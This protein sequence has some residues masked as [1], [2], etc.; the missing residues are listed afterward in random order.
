MMDEIHVSYFWKSPSRSRKTACN[1][2]SVCPLLT[3]I[4]ENM[5]PISKDFFQSSAHDEL[6]STMPPRTKTFLKTKCHFPKSCKSIVA[7]SIMTSSNQLWAR[8]IRP[9]LGRNP[10]SASHPTTQSRSHVIV[11]IT[12]SSPRI[13]PAAHLL[14]PHISQNPYALPTKRPAPTT[15]SLGL[16]TRP[17]HSLRQVQ[18]RSRAEQRADY[19]QYIDTCLA[20]T[21]FRYFSGH[22]F[23]SE[24]AL[25]HGSVS[26][27][28]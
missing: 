8:V 19:G 15:R 9:S 10:E 3:L 26:V 12:P 18:H 1:Y 2:A 23:Q 22:F 20:V 11:A 7:P 24:C 5:H 13:S 14:P 21:A 16:Q 28:G 6:E 25:R 17:R 27:C 4:E